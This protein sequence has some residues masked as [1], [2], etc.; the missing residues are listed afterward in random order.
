MADYQY[1]MVSGH[2]DFMG[3]SP[4][5][6]TK[7]LNHHVDG[8]IGADIIQNFTLII[9]PPS[10]KITVS[11]DTLEMPIIFPIEVFMGIPIL[12]VSVAGTKLRAFLDTGAHLSYVDS[13]LTGTIIPILQLYPNA[14][15][16]NVIM[17]IIHCSK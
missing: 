15:Y 14:L 8:L 7:Q 17:T 13:E 12:T 11:G 6:L 5:Y 4:E 16:G 10:Q 9:D 1:G 3:I 2:N